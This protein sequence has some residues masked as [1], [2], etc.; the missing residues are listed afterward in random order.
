MSYDNSVDKDRLLFTQYN[1]LILLRCLICTGLNI[2][3]GHCKIFKNFPSLWWHIK[4]EHADL[5]PAEREEIIQILNHVFKA[6]K[7]QMFPKWAYSEAI[8]P[9]KVPT[10]S[11]SSIL[12]DGRRPRMDAWTKIFEIAKLLKTQSEIFPSFKTRHLKAVLKGVLGSVDPRTTKKYFD[13]VTNYSKKDLV[14]G[15]FDV[16]GFCDKVGV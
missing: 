3:L 12:L 13:C 10:T 11:S 14:K 16:T 7:G 2:F 8:T 15:E 5:A 6:F 4:R 1:D 9:N